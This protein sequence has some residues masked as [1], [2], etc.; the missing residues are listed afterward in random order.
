VVF[1][2]HQLERPRRSLFAL[3]LRAAHPPGT[4]GPA[5][6]VG[7][8]TQRCFRDGCREP[9]RLHTYDGPIVCEAGHPLPQS[10]ERAWRFLR[11]ATSG[12]K[13]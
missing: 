9:V 2:G 3:V 10:S 11:R 12:V 7:G 8:V 1:A 6:G 13:A 5:R 4:G